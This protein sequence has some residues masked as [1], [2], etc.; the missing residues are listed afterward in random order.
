MQEMASV[1]RLRASGGG[2][3]PYVA[4]TANVYFGT[5]SSV[6][7]NTKVLILDTSGNILSTT[8]V[9]K[10]AGN[11]VSVEISEPPTLSQGSTYYVGII[12]DGYVPF[13]FQGSSGDCDQDSTGSYASPPDPVSIPGTYSTT[14]TP[15]V[16]IENSDGETLIGE[17]NLTSA[18]SNLING[19]VVYYN[20][21][22][23]VVP[24]L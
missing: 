13:Y 6:G 7:N 12:N 3:T 19:A 20:D 15:V 14:F 2:T 22:G 4:H 5:N 23:Y 10:S 11:V 1:A 18:S 16:W 21:D 8:I 24:A 9:G 17:D